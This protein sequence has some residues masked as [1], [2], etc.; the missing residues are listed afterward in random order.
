[1]G[2]IDGDYDLEINLYIVFENYIVVVEV[3]YDNDLSKNG[4]LIFCLLDYFKDLLLSGELKVI[5]YYN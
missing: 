1:M 4:V 3:Y 5:V 2:G